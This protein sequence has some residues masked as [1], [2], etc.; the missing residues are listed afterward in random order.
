LFIYI[1]EY[2]LFYSN[3]VYFHFIIIIQKIYTDNMFRT[4]HLALDS[5]SEKHAYLIIQDQTLQLIL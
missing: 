3:K 1:Y 2:F 4:K 5:S